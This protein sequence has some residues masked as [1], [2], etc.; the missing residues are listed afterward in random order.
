MPQPAQVL[1]DEA[2][3]GLVVGRRD[4]G[5]VEPFDLLVGQGDGEST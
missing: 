3:T 1:S 4:E 2:A 5:A